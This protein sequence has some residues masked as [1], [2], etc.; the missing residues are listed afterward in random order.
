MHFPTELF[1]GQLQNKD[2][3]VQMLCHQYRDTYHEYKM[4]Y[5]SSWESLY[6]CTWKEGFHIGMFFQ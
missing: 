1:L 4:V 3:E 6:T 2:V 5:I